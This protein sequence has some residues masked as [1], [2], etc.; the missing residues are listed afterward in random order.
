MVEA[1]Q[2]TAVEEIKT[3]AK[4]QERMVRSKYGMLEIFSYAFNRVDAVLM[5][6]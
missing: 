5:L 4:V 6:R 3:V 1:N 2:V